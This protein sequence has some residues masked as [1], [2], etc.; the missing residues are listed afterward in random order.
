MASKM[1]AKPT[2]DPMPPELSGFCLEQAPLP[3]VAVVGETHIVRYVNPAFRRL[4]NR[5]KKKLVG[6]P[7]HEMLPKRSECLAL[8]ERVYRTGRP[9]SSTEREGSDQRPVFSSYTMW[10][11]MAYGRVAGVMIQVNETAPLYE[12]TIA[13]NEAL[14][15]GS[16]RQHELTA[17]AKSSNIEL[18]AAVGEGKQR[19]REAQTLTNE[20]SHRIKNSLQIVSTLIGY[21][22]M[23]AAAPCV[24][25]YEAMQARI[26]AIAE[27]YDLI[28][29]SRRGQTISADEYLKEIAKTVSTSLLGKTSRIKIEVEAEALDIDPNYA[30]PFGLLVNELATNAIRH[31]FPQGAGRVTLSLRRTGDQIELCVADDGVGMKNEDSAK[32][33]GRHGGTYVAIFVR[34]LR[35][36]LAVLESE[37]SG[38]TFSI[39]L[40]TL[41]DPPAASSAQLLRAPRYIPTV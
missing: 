32:T 16:L 40:P 25:G 19:E 31:A 34:Q 11:V 4:I 6:T 30:V 29:Q 39:R 23:R 1:A 12:K 20:I 38:T 18:Q 24:K 41:V 22:A 14:I 17:D 35:G 26:K 10:P 9:E 37:G 28:S 3:M 5:G 15:L 7:F 33:P 8:L 21:E 36:T 27:L 2:S 13:M